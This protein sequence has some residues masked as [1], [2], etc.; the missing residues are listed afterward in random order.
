LHTY[1]NV[2]LDGACQHWTH[3]ALPQG[4]SLVSLD[5]NLGVPK[6]RSKRFSEQKNVLLLPGHE[7]EILLTQ[8]SL[9]FIKV[10]GTAP[11]G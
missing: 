10:V 5:R 7:T 11:M 1:L 6:R 9:Q 2:A 4:Q 3:V 8:T